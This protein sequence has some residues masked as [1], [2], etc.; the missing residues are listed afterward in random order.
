MNEMS[1]TILNIYIVIEDKKV[2]KFKV[3]AYE[4][5]ASQLKGN[6]LGVV[7]PKSVADVREIVAKT[8]RVVIRGAGTGLAGGCVPQNGL[9]VVL[10]M[11]KMDKILGL[12]VERRTINIEAGVILDDLQDY[13]AEHNLEFPVSPFSHA[14]CTIGGMISTDAVG[15]RAIKYGKTSNWVKWI[16]V[17][18]DKGNL[19][20][21][22]ITELSDYSGMEGITGVIVRACLKL[23]SKKKRTG[24]LVSV[25]N[26]NDI[27]SIVR[28]L[29][30][31][32]AVSMIEFFGRTVSK[33]I[34]LGDNYHLI[35]EYENDSGKLSDKEY[36]DILELR[37]KMSSIMIE[38]GY[39]YLEDPKVLLDRSDRLIEWLEKKGVPVFGHIGVG[40]F[41]P[42]FNEEQKEHIPEMMKLVKRLGGQISGEHGIGILKKEFVEVNDKRILVNVKKRTDP[43]NKFNVGKVI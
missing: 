8:N 17:V 34:G 22:G 25:N 28:N 12:D 33:K 20:R 4:S 35:I 40:I 31:N 19:Y 3:K 39:T 21:K 1:E 38:A 42:R 29:K 36:N 5:D 10:D 14:V 6:A 15:S 41:H 24:S 13:I 9:D 18:D 23:S 2:V 16:E 7:F 27:I 11:S 26:Y 30:R 32:S 37:G 43:L